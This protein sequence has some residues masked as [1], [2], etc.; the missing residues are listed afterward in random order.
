MTG[1]IAKKEQAEDESLREVGSA[2][3]A[4][5]KDT[6]RPKIRISTTDPLMQINTHPGLNVDSCRKQCSDTAGCQYW[7]LD[8][9]QTC[10]LL[11]DYKTRRFLKDY[12]SGDVLCK[13]NMLIVV[14][15]DFLTMVL[16]IL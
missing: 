8:P 10:T 5:C 2:D 1:T 14:V 16:A 15:R 7:S 12:S 11:K 3:P 4:I 6:T 9:E 13:C